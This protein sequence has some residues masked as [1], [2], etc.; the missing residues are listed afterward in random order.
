MNII[1]G[2]VNQYFVAAVSLGFYGAAGEVV[3]FPVVVDTGF[4]G[5]ICMPTAEVKRLGLQPSK[6]RPMPM[7]NANG[8]IVYAPLYMGKV[9]WLGNAREVVIICLGDE[10]LLGMELLTACKLTI[11]NRIVRIE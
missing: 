8:Q 7:K 2:T 9:N 11:E 3:T 1:T 5:Q 4:D 6:A 10:T